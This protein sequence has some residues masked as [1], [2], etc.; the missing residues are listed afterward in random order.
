[1]P[2]VGGFGCFQLLFYFFLDMGLEW[3]II[4]ITSFSAQVW[5]NN[6]CLSQERH[7][8][9]WGNLCQ[10]Q[11]QTRI[12]SSVVNKTILTGDPQIF[13]VILGTKNSGSHIWEINSSGQKKRSS[14][15]LSRCSEELEFS[16]IWTNS[17]FINRSVRY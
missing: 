4:I 3:I 17:V 16:S 2:L 5:S 7:S 13:S 6:V 1:M 9:R 14:N 10:L 12:C 11:L 8:Q 15:G